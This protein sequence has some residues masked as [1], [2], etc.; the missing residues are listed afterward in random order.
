MEL[1][2]LKKIKNRITKGKRR[3]RG[4][5]SGRGGHTI[6]RG[7]KGQK[8]RAGNSLPYGFEGGQVPLYKKLPHI[9]G[10][11]NPNPRRQ[12]VLTLKSLNNLKSGTKVTPELLVKENIIKIIP[13]DG[14]KI[15][16][17]GDIDKKLTFE[18]ITFS[19][20]ARKKLEEAGCTVNE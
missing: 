14:I 16:A 13:R 4:I 9:G 20:G 1:H 18:G 7:T 12:A 19:A 6:G 17:S 10:F 11:K 3:G 15:I 5:G 2:N 8:A